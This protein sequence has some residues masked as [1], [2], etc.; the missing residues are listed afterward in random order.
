MWIGIN[1]FIVKKSVKT[2]AYVYL[3]VI[4]DYICDIWLKIFLI[5]CGK[6][7]SDKNITLLYDK[8]NT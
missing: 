6:H 3:A 4:V 1:H 5:K 7:I 8:V 2:A